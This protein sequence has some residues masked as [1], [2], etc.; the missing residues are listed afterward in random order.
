MKPPAMV[1]RADVPPVQHEKGD[2]QKDE[3]AG[4]GHCLMVEQQ[5]GQRSNRDGARL[6]AT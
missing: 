5:V 1:M 4:G 6:A 3:D 2:Q